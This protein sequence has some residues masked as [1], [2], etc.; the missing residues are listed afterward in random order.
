[1]G[2]TR[3][4]RAT[5]LTGAVA[6]AISMVF[7]AASSRAET[8]AEAFAAAYETNPD[9]I[10][11]RAALRARDETVNQARA[12]MRP[13]VS[14]I[15]DY[16]L[17]ATDDSA[18]GSDRNDPFGAELQASQTL[19]DGGQTSNA[20]RGRIADVSAER[21]RLTSLEQ[22]VM[23]AVATA[24]LDV[25]RDAEFVRLATNNVRVIAEQL[26]ATQDRFEVG[27]VT[28]TD[29]S[30]A[31]ARLAEADANLSS[32]QGQLEQSRQRYRQIV[33][34]EPQSL[35][36][37][38]T[39]PVTPS[40]LE[41]AVTM[42]MENHPDAIAARF[43]EVSA[44]R[45]IRTAIG[46][47][48]PNVSLNAS[49]GYNEDGLLGS[50]DLDQTQATVGV[51]AVVPLYQGGAQYSRVRQAQAGAS[52]ARAQITS[53]ARRLRQEVEGAWSQLQ[54]ARATIRAGRQRVEAAR[55]AFEGVREEALVGSRTTLDVLDA[56]QEVLN[57]STSLVSSVR[58]EYVAAYNLLAAVG[59]LTAAQQGLTVAAYDPDVNY[60]ENN[61]RAFGFPRTEDTQWEEF[62]RP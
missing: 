45:D 19:Y 3:M 15:L 55:L 44:T 39:P 4:S 6:L 25:Q 59:A 26:R 38:R 13:N 50:R 30:Q 5:V 12:G 41:D 16:G 43:D 21:A 9:L 2:K 40:S 1:M 29:V 52:A 7:S 37:P 49:V 17:A 60:V 23:L 42:A 33:G 53:E 54:V 14:A 57:A 27:E 35:V 62:W 11:A 58:D 32:Q 61:D 56:E 18:R 46:G 36:L 48:L 47:L 31:E 8:L 34:T 22:Q 51:R 28:R 24:Y 20:V 10:A